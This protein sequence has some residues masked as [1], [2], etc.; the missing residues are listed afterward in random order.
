MLGNSLS[1]IPLSLKDLRPNQTCSSRGCH[2]SPV[3]SRYEPLRKVIKQKD[4]KSRRTHTY[5]APV[6]NSAVI[7][8][9]QIARGVWGSRLHSSLV[10]FFKNG[11]RFHIGVTISL[12]R[13]PGLG[14][15]IPTA[16]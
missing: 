3:F 13:M 6:C 14:K 12:D 9:I 4:F 5:G 7:T 10:Q 8:T 1:S 16:S 2:N 15:R 11:L